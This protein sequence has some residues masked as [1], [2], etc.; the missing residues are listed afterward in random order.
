MFD[1][2]RIALFC[3]EKRLT[4]HKMIV[5]LPRPWLLLWER[6]WRGGPG[7]IA[8]VA[9]SLIRLWVHLLI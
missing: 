9:L 3:L 4:R 5:F 8:P 1:F 2:R 7:A 6:P